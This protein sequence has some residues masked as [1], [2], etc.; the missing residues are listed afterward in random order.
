MAI[1]AIGVIVVI[2]AIGVIVVAIRAAYETENIIL[3]FE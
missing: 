1:V 3:I 2:V